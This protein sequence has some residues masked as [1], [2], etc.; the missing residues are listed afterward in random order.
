MRHWVANPSTSPECG[1]GWPYY[2][3]NPT[4]DLKEFERL[5]VACNDEP[6]NAVEQHVRA[7][8]LCTCPVPTMTHTQCPM[9]GDDDE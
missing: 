3:P 1:C 4:A 5:I 6:V 7:E 9:H 2:G 8:N